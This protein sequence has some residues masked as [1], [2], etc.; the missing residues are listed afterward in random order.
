M[1]LGQFIRMKR[2][3][4]GMTE[5]ELAKKT[6]LSQSYLSQLEGGSRKAPSHEI[7]RK[8][9]EALEVS[10]AELETLVEQSRSPDRL[11]RLRY[12]VSTGIRNLERLNNLVAECERLASCMAEH[13][14]QSSLSSQA[15]QDLIA[16]TDSP[17]ERQAEMVNRL[18]RY[19]RAASLNKEVK[20]LHTRVSRMHEEILPL[21]KRLDEKLE[22]PHYPEEIERLIIEAQSLG[23]SGLAYLSRQ[24]ELASRFFGKSAQTH[25][26]SRLE[27]E[28]EEE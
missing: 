20:M 22:Y 5:V 27:T 1:V 25:M 19:E 12:L 17:R 28:Q 3:E 9:A 10:V 18:H 26:A 4:K 15:T 7:L 6:G 21:L 13:A 23:P 11:N 14:F 2:A 8:L 16:G 24:I